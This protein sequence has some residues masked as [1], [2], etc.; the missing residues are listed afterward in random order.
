M[1]VAPC[2][3]CASDNLRATT[4][5]ASSPNGPDLLPGSHGFFSRSR[6]EVVV[7]CACGLTRFFASREE[8]ERVL[9][10]NRWHR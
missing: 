1:T 4:A 10:S 9:K 2:P 8:I 3:N 6:F 7:C 5:D